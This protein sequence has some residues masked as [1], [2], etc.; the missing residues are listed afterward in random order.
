MSIG[1]AVL[2]AVSSQLTVVGDLAGGVTLQNAS[3]SVDAPEGVEVDEGGAQLSPGVFVAGSELAG[4]LPPFLLSCNT[5]LPPFHSDFAVMWLSWYPFSLV[6][7]VQSL[8][9]W[10]AGM[11]VCLVWVD[12]D[13]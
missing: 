2:Q 4:F 8:M 3:S 12:S 13:T 1:D 9:I 6:S 11:L 5:G 10:F 7:Q